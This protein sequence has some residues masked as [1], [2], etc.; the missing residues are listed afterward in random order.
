MFDLALKQKV[1]GSDLLTDG[2]P[3]EQI[4]AK[5]LHLSSRSR[6]RLSV[7]LRPLQSCARLVSS[8]HLCLRDLTVV[9]P[10]VRYNE[11]YKFPGSLGIMHKS[12][13]VNVLL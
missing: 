12:P 3:A 8:P 7:N 11:T 10:I 9:M 4:G 1:L 6:C 13:Y 2:G 5:R